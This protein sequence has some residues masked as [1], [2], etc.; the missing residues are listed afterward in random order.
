MGKIYADIVLKVKSCIFYTIQ[1]DLKLKQYS[2]NWKTCLKGSDRNLKNTQEEVK[3]VKKHK[4]F[5]CISYIRN[6]KYKQKMR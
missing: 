3:L 1:I 5:E 4:K 6:S 2:L